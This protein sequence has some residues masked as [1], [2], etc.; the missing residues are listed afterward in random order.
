[1]RDSRQYEDFEAVQALKLWLKGAFGTNSDGWV[2]NDEWD[3]ARVK[4]RAAYGEW[5][6]TARESDA[7]DEEMTVEKAEKMWPFD[8]R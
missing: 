2:P 4:H 5:I 7:N 6:E 1:M 8:A 3:A